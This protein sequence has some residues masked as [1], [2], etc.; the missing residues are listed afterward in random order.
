MIPGMGGETAF[1]RYQTQIYEQIGEPQRRKIENFM[2]HCCMEAEEIT[3]GDI[4]ELYE[5]AGMVDPDGRLGLVEM[6]DKL[7]VGAVGLKDRRIALRAKGTIEG[8]LRQTWYGKNADV[9]NRPRNAV[10]DAVAEGLERLREESLEDY[11]MEHPEY[12]KREEIEDQNVQKKIKDMEA[13]IIE[14]KQDLTLRDQLIEKLK[15]EVERITSGAGRSL[16]S[17]EKEPERE[18]N[19]GEMKE[20]PG[21]VKEEVLEFKTDRYWK[22]E[23][24]EDSPSEVNLEYTLVPPE[25][26]DSYIPLRVSVENEE[27]G[28]RVGL[29]QFDVHFS[30][31][32]HYEMF[33]NR[34]RSVISGYLDKGEVVTTIPVRDSFTK[35]MDFYPR[36][37]GGEVSR[38]Q[39][40][41]I[42]VRHF[43][44]DCFLTFTLGSSYLRYFV[45]LPRDS[46]PE[47]LGDIGDLVEMVMKTGSAPERTE[48]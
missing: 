31:K 28:R 18:I 29:I 26:F 34:L 25:K 41:K 12:G 15:G 37:E 13:M 46:L 4:E 9:D 33:F 10:A 27:G 44:E 43:R 5:M 36:M 40:G 2:D 11:L 39:I 42:D 48:R 23:Y 14:L 20:V 21:M 7:D 8:Y 16:I 38:V 22:L 3:D 6:L 35:D 32:E 30:G 1:Q 19:T 17:M 24:R 45:W 47:F